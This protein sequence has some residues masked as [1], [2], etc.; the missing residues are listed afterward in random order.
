MTRVADRREKRV[1][2]RDFG[3]GGRTAFVC[4]SSAG[5]GRACASALAAHGAVVWIN[6]R[7]EERVKRTA[8]EL[9]REHG[10]E[11]RWLVADVTTAEGRAA[12]LEAC[13]SPDILVNNSD[14]PRPG[15]FR[16]FGEA[17]WHAAL[18]A[19]M[20]SPILLIRQY[21]DGMIGRGWGRIVNITS[22]SV[23]APLP[24]LGLS[25]GARSGLTGFVA[26]LAREV[27]ASGVTINNILP[28]RMSTDRLSSYVGALAHGEG[29]A[30][31]AVAER[32]AQSNPMKRFGRPEELGALC[33]FVASTGAAYI[34][35]QNLIVDGGE[36]L[37]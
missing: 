23:K 31:E 10:A 22:T 2:F 29:V 27:A 34:T 30:A 13:P 18:S 21:L 6:G 12:M 5:L 14:G 35:G 19:N 8:D 16:D 25:N 36:Y 24:L 17:E 37:G 15:D 4:G 9:A 11:T 7:T 32:L 28:G 3:I 20:V 33:A 1:D 26:G